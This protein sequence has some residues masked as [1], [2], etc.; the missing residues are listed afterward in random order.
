MSC[1]T[2][3]EATCGHHGVCMSMYELALHSKRNGDAI[4]ITYGSDVNNVDTWDGHKIHGCLCD[5]GYGGYNCGYKNC[6]RG[7]DPGT[8]DD[9][10]EVQIASDLERELRALPSILALSV[11]YIYD[12]LPPSDVLDTSGISITVPSMVN[13]SLCSVDGNQLAIIHYTHTHGDVPALQAS[14]KY[15]MDGMNSNNELGSGMI[16]VFADGQ[17]IH[18]LVSLAGTTETD[19][20]NNRGLCDGDA[21]VCKCFADWTSSDGARQG[22]EGYTN[23]CGYRNDKRFTSFD[24]IKP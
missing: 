7:D 11:Y 9:Y 17:A 3:R 1:P 15:L 12:A 2:H 8:Y 6:I 18:G 13:S 10:S 22:G 23:D 4:S 14:N 19:F 24:S 5:A 21:G 20:C 16:H